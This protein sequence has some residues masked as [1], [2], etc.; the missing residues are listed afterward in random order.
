[1]SNNYSTRETD[2]SFYFFVITFILVALG[3]AYLL[4]QIEIPEIAWQALLI[5]LLV[6][7]IIFGIFFV[8]EL[9][10]NLEFLGLIFGFII[11]AFALYRLLRYLLSLA[12]F[13]TLI[14]ALFVVF[15]TVLL[16]AFL[17]RI[18]LELQL[19]LKFAPVVLIC[20]ALVVL[21][22]QSEGLFL[23]L[24]AAVFV[25]LPVYFLTMK[26]KPLTGIESMIGATGIV[27]EDFIQEEPAT[28]EYYRG[29]I[30]IGSTIW[31]ARSQSKL[32]KDDIVE[33]LE[34]WEHLTLN[35]RPK[36]PHRVKLRPPEE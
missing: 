34:I 1:M 24:L 21:I 20:L 16:L 12:F 17:S 23:S 29:R 30:K 14:K 33:V 18:L 3:S 26:K 8:L 19:L 28:T 36:S 27:I 35:V 31:R 15:F 2:R 32:Q 11:A 22:V 25:A 7:V 4:S 6:L 5:L 9:L 10:E 13:I